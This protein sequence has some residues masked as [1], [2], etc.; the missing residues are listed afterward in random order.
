MVR[1]AY[2]R[3]GNSM[4]NHEEGCSGS[5]YPPSNFMGFMEQHACCPAYGKSCLPLSEQVRRPASDRWDCSYN[6]VVI[7]AYTLTARLPRVIE[8][9]LFPTSCPIAQWEGLNGEAAAIT[10]RDQFV[11]KYGLKAGDVPVLSFSC[12]EARAGRG[13]FLH[14]A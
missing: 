4:G 7:N 12:S 13:P 5:S 9:F 1:C 8:S 14:V 2:P 10:V 3:D 6:E 11:D